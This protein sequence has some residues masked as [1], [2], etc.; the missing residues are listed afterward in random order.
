MSRLRGRVARLE[1]RLAERARDARGGLNDEDRAHTSAWFAHTDHKY[2]GG[3]APTPEQAELLR[4]PGFW[5]RLQEAW[6]RPAFA[7]ACM[8]ATEAAHREFR[9]GAV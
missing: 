5:N 1:Q 3:E 9:A 2:R 4:R 8:E 6:G 7:R